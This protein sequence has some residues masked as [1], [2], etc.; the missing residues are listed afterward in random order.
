[1]DYQP[2]E[3]NHLEPKLTCNYTGFTAL[4]HKYK[5]DLMFAGHLHIYQRFLPVLGPKTLAPYERS[6]F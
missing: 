2:D 6:V 5:V 1:M 3:H 4:A